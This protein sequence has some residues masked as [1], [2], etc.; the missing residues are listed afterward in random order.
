MMIFLL[1][2]YFERFFFVLGMGICVLSDLNIS[3]FSLIPIT[4]P[5]TKVISN[6]STRS[7][8]TDVT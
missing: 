8:N 5:L 2:F 7:S 3:E 1:F 6:V 4:I